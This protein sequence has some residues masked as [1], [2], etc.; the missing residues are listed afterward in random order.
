MLFQISLII[1]SF[2]FM[3]IV[4]F[5]S[6]KYIMHGFL[7]NWHKD[8]HQSVRKRFYRNDLFVLLFASPAILVMLVSQIFPQMKNLIFVGIG[9]TLYGFVYSLVHEVLIHRR[10]GSSPS[11]RNPYLRAI[12]KAH[13]VHHRSRDKDADGPF[14]LLIVSPKYFKKQ[15]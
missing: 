13:L 1:F 15:S 11:F 4:A 12:L 9:I 8:H 2:I 10:F 14:G 6:H 5:L 7:W 3:E